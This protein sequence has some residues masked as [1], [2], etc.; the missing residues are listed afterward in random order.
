MSW[1]INYSAQARQDLRSLYEYIATEFCAPDT[2]ANQARRIMQG[3][4]TL[5][6]MPMRHRLYEAEPFHSM[7]LHFIPVNNYLIFYLPKEAEE[8]I[9][10][11]RIM[12]GGRN[13]REQLNEIIEF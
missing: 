9:N 11:V 2:A 3:I 13:I 12:Y 1:K 6:D 8:V 7:G 10:I 4:R 5:Q